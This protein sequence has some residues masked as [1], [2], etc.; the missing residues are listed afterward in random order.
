M[1]ELGFV[2]EVA[3]GYVDKY[4]TK[5]YYNKMEL[6]SLKE[7]LKKQKEKDAFANF[8][9]EKMPEVVGQGVSDP[10]KTVAEL[11]K[12]WGKLSDQEKKE[13]EQKPKAL[14]TIVKKE[15]TETKAFIPKGAKQLE[16][17]DKEEQEMRNQFKN[18]LDEKYTEEAFRLYRSEEYKMRRDDYPSF[19][20]EEINDLIKQ[21]WD[22][23][24]SEIKQDFAL[25]SLL[26]KRDKLFTRNA[27]LT[28]LLRFDHVVQRDFMKKYI[29][30]DKNYTE[31]YKIWIMSGET[32]KML[33]SMSKKRDLETQK[34]GSGKE[35]ETQKIVQELREKAT[36]IAT[37]N[38][39][40][41][42]PTDTYLQI[43]KNISSLLE[44]D[45]EELHQE[46]SKDY[47]NLAN[48]L[49][50]PPQRDI[51][52]ASL[53]ESIS[54]RKKEI[55]GRSDP[56]VW[57]NID[58]MSREKLLKRAK[59]LE[60]PEDYSDTALK[61]YLLIQKG[62]RI[63]SDKTSSV[64]TVKHLIPSGIDEKQ[65]EEL[66]EEKFADKLKE[67][68][69]EEK[70]AFVGNKVYAISYIT[71]EK[72]RLIHLRMED[73]E[74]LEDLIF[75][76]EADLGGKKEEQD[77]I[78]PFSVYSEERETTSHSKYIKY[79]AKRA[80]P[81]MTYEEFKIMF[82]SE[83]VT[84]EEY[85]Y[86]L[87]KVV[88]LRDLPLEEED[89]DQARIMR[90]KR[91]RKNRK[92]IR[93]F[94]AKPV[95]STSVNFAGS[96]LEISLPSSLK[97][98]EEDADIENRE[99][100][101]EKGFSRSPGEIEDELKE[102]IVDIRKVGPTKFPGQIPAY[103]IPG[104]AE[105]KGT[106][107]DA[108][109]NGARRKI[110]KVLTTYQHFSNLSPYVRLAIDSV[111][112]GEPDQTNA[113]LFS[114]IAD[115]TVYLELN[116]AKSFRARVKSRYYLPETLMSLSPEDKLPEVFNPSVKQE[117]QLEVANYV[118]R[119]LE[120]TVNEMATKML[121]PEKQVRR[122]AS[123]PEPSVENDLSFCANSVGD[124]K[125][126]EVVY[127]KDEEDGQVYCFKIDEVSRILDGDRLNP[128]TG[129]E[130]SEEFAERFKSIYNLSFKKQGFF[131]PSIFRR[132]ALEEDAGNALQLGQGKNTY[133]FTRY[134]EEKK[135]YVTVEL[136]FEELFDKF[137]KGDYAL[138]SPLVGVFDKAFVD[139]ILTQGRP[140][141]EPQEEN[142]I[143]VPDL[144]RVLVGTVDELETKVFGEIRKDL[145]EDEEEA[146]PEEEEVVDEPEEEE[147]PEPEE[148][149]ESSEDSEDEPP[150]KKASTPAKKGK[151]DEEESSADSTDE[152]PKKAKKDD[153]E[154]SADS[155]DETPK[156]DKKDDEESSA[157]STD[158]TPKKDDDESSADS[159]DETPTKKKDTDEE[160]SADSTD[161]TPKKGKAKVAFGEQR[162]IFCG[163]SAKNDFKTLIYDAKEDKTTPVYFCCLKCM[164]EY[165][166][167]NYRRK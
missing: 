90:E 79:L 105:D 66:I 120:E 77:E 101:K 60:N 145:G 44:T 167:P 33:Q 18:I 141:P 15:K 161:E 106:G 63:E 52:I 112:Y 65:A 131:E 102:V 37:E 84:R 86:Y 103:A 71:P 67:M 49:G 114:R 56:S 159:T 72:A 87:D 47:L 73:G 12:M 166:F 158:E 125:F 39:I 6:S 138:P 124:A 19:S 20:P 30:Q 139:M 97:S 21:E 57:R 9:E 135:E 96:F 36:R 111:L 93:N 117:K 140:K 1:T 64:G 59:N 69:K 62:R 74:K 116:M 107:G 91:A 148:E 134:N 43:L 78:L 157:D 4:K 155:T 85:V 53:A 54:R 109:E 88:K 118:R 142:V 154:S 2:L 83:D 136:T 99:E 75:L 17:V 110:V 81:I 113:S 149:E 7:R 162:C 127:Y 16:S 108:K 80:P 25:Q 128:V 76:T 23:L 13:Y 61:F 89:L 82:G 94:L 165:N 137:S 95:S 130:F 70:E 48:V 27:L 55:L 144:W 163:E 98:V 129:R 10:K 68:K 51:N 156:K 147:E 45:L 38:G 50:I 8:S 58:G 119:R 14:V 3:R 26:N 35:T 41:V 115:V 31:F 153:E 123:Y 104:K 24:D 5:K 34:V 143:L 160:S 40:V 122:Q 46:I 151:D 92:M 133:K 121:F 11:R 150:P 29:V 22:E 132:Y 126:E 28:N 100:K 32:Q 152:T 164:E 146:E 42:K